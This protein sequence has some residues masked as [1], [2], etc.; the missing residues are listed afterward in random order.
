MIYFGVRPSKTEAKLLLRRRSK[1][2][3]TLICK[4]KFEKGDVSLYLV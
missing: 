3:P 1:L 2:E 4:R